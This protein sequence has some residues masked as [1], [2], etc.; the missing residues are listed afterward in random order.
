MLREGSV[1]FVIGRGQARGARASD[2]RRRAWTTLLR[3]LTC[4]RGL[5][6]QGCVCYAL[7]NVAAS[8]SAGV[9]REPYAALLLTTP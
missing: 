1:Q 9:Q 5:A 3:C 6:T 8:C 2:A 4:V 7:I